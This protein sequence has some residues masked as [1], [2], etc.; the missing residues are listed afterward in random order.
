MVLSFIATGRAIMMMTS[1][2]DCQVSL[3]AHWNFHSH[4]CIS[5]RMSRRAISEVK[6]FWFCAQ[7][8]EFGNIISPSSLPSPS[9]SLSPFRSFSCCHCLPHLH[10]SPPSALRPFTLCGRCPPAR[11]S[12]RRS[13]CLSRPRSVRLS[14]LVAGGRG[15]TDGRTDGQDPHRIGRGR[16]GGRACVV[17]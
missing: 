11:P 14:K 1:P 6:E 4:T 2:T 12:I 17:R 5:F 10:C 13:R 3:R 16:R 9:L 8:C 7:N 15:R